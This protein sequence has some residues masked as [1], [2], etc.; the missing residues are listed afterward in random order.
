VKLRT[1]IGLSLV[2]TALYAHKQRGGEFT[3]DSMKDSLKSLW[4][5]IQNKAADVK[6]DAER[7]AEKAKV[8][9]PAI[10]PA[11]PYNPQH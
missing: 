3:V 1:I 4:N 2:G 11:T 9:K 10:K 5:G 7:F 8:S 6:D